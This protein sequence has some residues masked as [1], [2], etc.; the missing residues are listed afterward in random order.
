MTL[1]GVCQHVAPFVFRPAACEQKM[2]DYDIPQSMNVHCKAH[3]ARRP[4][5]EGQ[6]TCHL[7]GVLIIIG[8]HIFF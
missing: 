4:G 1:P 8:W 5:E 6:E 7:Y 2:H 3:C